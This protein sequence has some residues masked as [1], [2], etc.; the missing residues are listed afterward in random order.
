MSDTSFTP[1]IAVTIDRQ[2][3]SYQAFITTAPAVLDAPST[4]TLYA[5]P[6]KEIVGLAIDEVAFDAARATTPTRLV[7]VDTTEVGGQRSRYR[8]WAHRLMPADPFLV[9]FNPLE[10]WLGSS[11]SCRRR[12]THDPFPKD[13]EEITS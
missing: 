8:A 10:Q 1:S 11:S 12:H 2:T 4:L 3:R 7:L 6:L 9:G 5:G 13:A